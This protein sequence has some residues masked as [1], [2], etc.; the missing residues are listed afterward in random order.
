MG[1]SSRRVVRGLL[2]ASVIIVPASA[3]A[4]RTF[5]Y[6]PSDYKSLTIST[7]TTMSF[8]VTTMIV[9]PESPS[10][11]PQ[12]NLQVRRVSVLLRPPDGA[13]GIYS[14]TYE[15][16]A[17]S[18]TVGSSNLDGELEATVQLPISVSDVGKVKLQWRN[19]LGGL[20]ESCVSPVGQ[21]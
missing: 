1:R 19:A 21:Q 5:A 13:T 18:V 16:Q 9:V 3:L 10:F 11:K 17:I 2:L 8:S 14:A 15:H 12:S 4:Q 20:S 6:L 7:P